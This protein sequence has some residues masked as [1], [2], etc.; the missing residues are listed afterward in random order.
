MFGTFDNFADKVAIQLNDTHPALAV[1][2]LMRILV[3]E[4]AFGWDR[5]WEVTQAV[6]GYTNHT[7][8]PEALEQWP[9]A[10]VERVLPRHLQIIYE[11][12]RRML[13]QV[14]AR[15]P[16]DEGRVQRMSLIAEGDER[17]VRMANLALAGSHKVNGVAAIHSDLVKRSLFPDFHAM[18]PDRFTSKTS[19]ITPRRWLLRANPELS[20]LSCA[21]GQRLDL[22]PDAPRR[23]G[24]LG[25]RSGLP[26]RVPPG[27]TRVQGAARPVARRIHGRAGRPHV[28]LRRPR[29]TDPRVQRRLLNALHARLVVAHPGRRGTGGAAGPRVRRKRRR[30]A[31]RARS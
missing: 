6:C 30:R 23:A 27:E 22:R 16:G 14:R 17:Q 10:L 18:W 1:A 25:R 9:V 7:L 21:R 8:L 20:A 28:A 3:D 12:N 31:T 4:R 11:I 29:Q 26:G 19:G 5:A 15:F 24:A 2:E 13:D